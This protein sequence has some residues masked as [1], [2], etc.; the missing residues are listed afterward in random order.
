MLNL[1]AIAPGPASVQIDEFCRREEGEILYL[2]HEGRKR[3]LSS[4][5]SLIIR[6]HAIERLADYISLR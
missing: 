3:R 2:E 1:S 4:R 6:S 5:Q